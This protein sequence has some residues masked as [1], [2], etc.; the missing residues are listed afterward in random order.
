MSTTFFFL[1]L[2]M[3][4]STMAIM[5]AGLT[6]VLADQK[7]DIQLLANMIERLQIQMQTDRLKEHHD[8][9]KKLELCY[10]QDRPKEVDP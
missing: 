9:L 8:L 6:R 2:T 3:C 5:M 10:S 4:V 1:L 7:A